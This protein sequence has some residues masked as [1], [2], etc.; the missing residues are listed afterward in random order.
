MTTLIQSVLKRSDLDYVTFTDSVSKIRVS[1]PESLIDTDFEYGLQSIK[2][3][4]LQL[5]NNIPTFFSRSGDT[6]IA[7]VDVTC[8][9]GQ[10]FIYVTTV[11]S[12]G[13]VN[14]APIYIAGLKSVTAEG[15]YVVTKVL[16]TTR[17]VYDAKFD[18]TVTG[19][20]FIKDNSYLFPGM[21]YKG[22]SFS[23]EQLD[24]MTTNEGTPGSTIT[25][26]TKTPHG[27][28]V[29]GMFTLAN[30]FGSKSVGT[31]NAITAPNYLINIPN[32]RLF[33]GMNV[34]LVQADTP[35]SNVATG[36]NVALNAVL[37]VI[38]IDR[39]NFRL[40]D[41][42]APTVPLQ[43]ISFSGQK[44][45]TTID[46]TTDGSEYTI[47]SIPSETVMNMDVL[48]Q[49]SGRTFTCVHASN[50]VVDAPLNPQFSN[51]LT[52][53]ATH[54]L[55]TGTVIALQTTTASLQGISQGN[56]FNVIRINDR[57]VALASSLQN[58]QNGVRVQLIPT[59]PITPSQLVFKT[60]SLL[61][62]EPG[63][64]TVTLT[65]GSSNVV[66]TG[67]NFLSYFRAGMTFRSLIGESAQ[68][69]Y[70]ISSFTNDLIN[71][72]P[73]LP[74]NNTNLPVRFLGSGPTNLVNSNVYYITYV[75][76]TQVNVRT[77]P[78]GATITPDNTITGVFRTIT[79]PYVFESQITQV[80]N[81]TSITLATA[82]PA[83]VTNT[84]YYVQTALYPF[85]DSYVYHRA[86]DG[87]IEMVPSANA[88]A[89][90]IRQTRKYFRYQPGKGIQCSLSINFSAPIDINVLQ[91]SGNVATV[92][93]RR[94]HR[95]TNGL[96]VSIYGTNAPGWADTVTVFNASSNTFSYTL[97]TIPSETTATGFPK[98]KLS[99]WTGSRIRAGLFDDHNGMFFEYDGNAMYA[100]RRDSVAQI[101]GTVD[102]YSGCNQV[103]AN[104]PTSTNFTSQLT[105]RQNVVIR[106]QTYRVVSIP[107]NSTFYIQPQ[108]RGVNEQNIIVSLVTDT[109]APSS[110]WSIDKCDGQGPTGYLLDVTKI[111]MIYM[112][113]SWYG[114]GKIRFGFKDSKGIVRYVHEF[115]HN[116]IFDTAYFRSGNL[117]ARYEV[118]NVGRPT[119]VPPLMHW[120]MAVIMDGRYDDDKAYLFTAN[121]NML[122]YT[123]GDTISIQAS[124]SASD[125]TLRRVYDPYAQQLVD[126]YSITSAGGLDTSSNSWARLQNLR[127]G[128]VVNGT[129]LTPANTFT[130]VGNPQK[131][132]TDPSRATI[133]VN[134]IPTGTVASATYTFGLTS[135]TIQPVIPLVSIRIAPSVD[136]SITGSLGV[137]ELV[138]HMQLRLRSVD[139]LTTNDTELR[140]YL[141]SFIDN[142]NWQAASPPSLSQYVAHVKGD[143]IQDGTVLFS[144]R[145]PGGIYDSAGKRTSTVT[146]YD[147]SG[148]GF[149][150]NSIL[151]G[152]SI[153]PDGP[154]VLTL[155]AVCLDPGGVSATTPYTVSA[156][157]TW[158][159]AQA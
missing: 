67:V 22:T 59:A 44:T 90:L 109:R 105:L 98:F 87:G 26:R 142:R 133:F 27:F 154:D 39:N 118:Y 77:I 1:T 122:N 130:T 51:T 158:A 52:F 11:A 8:I 75:S 92:T 91:R 72:T 56:E 37:T 83:S 10:N 111:Q 150:G 76:S 115:A 134:R 70:T 48:E 62:E 6:P 28:T 47:T 149:L 137:R 104:P 94:P 65:A 96:S 29:G 24:S 138:N 151:G 57:T 132:D 78:G 114:A 84:P 127:S 73:P 126:A 82:A 43:L 148:L 74:L 156:R 157:V 32:H 33:T 81:S 159:E 61:G 15:Y 79:Y 128:T 116:N 2:W 46:S 120:G 121:G 141:N 106:G 152:D 95:L 155:A 125:R 42:I 64:G 97:N 7:L 20:I 14:G 71:I 119:W 49:V 66:G 58:A 140:L 21:V 63:P 80:R 35:L 23:A 99:N 123:N 135:D 113:Y 143:T 53:N 85:S 107:N 38:S 30:S 4:T 147:V 3:E 124:I 131:N 13:L 25:V 101:S 144:Y 54:N 69:T 112:D 16:S 34:T 41:T 153:Y 40:A 110:Q 93:T 136:S 146:S 145:V 9:S 5:V 12:H 45:F 18:Q 55:V 117:P 102:V 129:S 68:T 103:F 31:T 17:F 89:Q 86:L 60:V 108:Y 50:M 88:D 36:Q 100:V 19:S 139:I